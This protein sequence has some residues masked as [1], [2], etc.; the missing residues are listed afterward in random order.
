MCPFPASGGLSVP[1]PANF[2]PSKETIVTR[3]AEQDAIEFTNYVD[4]L[5]RE[6]DNPPE[7][8]IE[9]F[10]LNAIMDGGKQY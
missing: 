1:A 3:S 2:N 6:L 7:D 9:N 4:A 5:L 10:G 8:R